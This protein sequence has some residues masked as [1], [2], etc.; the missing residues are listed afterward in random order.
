MPIHDWTRVDVGIFHDFHH[1]WIFTIKCALNTGIL[2]PDYY[3]LAEQVAG[4]FHPDVLTLERNH[5]ASPAAGGNGPSAAH[6]SNGIVALATAP[7][8]VRFTAAAE[9]ERHAR[10]RQRITIRH[11]SDDQ[12]VAILEIVSSGNKGNRH[13]LQSFIE[14][15]VGVLDA[16]IHLLTLDLFPPGPR[17]PQGIHAAIWS[18]IVD[19]SFQ[20]PP[21]KPLTLASYAAGD[22][23]RAFIEPVSVGDD[24]P[25][26][27]LFL[28][29]GSYV[30]VPLQPT[31]LAAFDAVPKR[32]RDELESSTA[33]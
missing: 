3:A 26:M 20:L 29:A 6:S 31:Y 28:E 1:D 16:G 2:P 27:P 30:T 18:Q 23:I 7:P 19:E 13:A 14:K 11:V 10:K 12:V 24:V 4:G 32:W 5:P 17:D 33:G 21:D 15:A 22:V 9:G 8:R 25:R